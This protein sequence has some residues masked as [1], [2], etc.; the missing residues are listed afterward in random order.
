MS[1]KSAFACFISLRRFAR[2]L[3]ILPFLSLFSPVFPSAAADSPL[4]AEA[5]D[6]HYMQACAAYGAG[7]FYIPGTDTCF[8][9]A[10]YVRS[11][12]KG[13]DNVYGRKAK[14]IRRDTYAWR[15]RASLRLSTAS[16]TDLGTLRS[17]VEF[18]SQWSAGAEYDAATNSEQHLRFAYLELG[19]LRLGMDD[20]IFTHWTNY[21]GNV[22]N[23]DVL[24]PMQN[25]R[26]NAVSYSFDTGGGFSAILGVEQG[27]SEGDSSGFR[28]Q[29]G[30]GKQVYKL[31]QQ[32]QD[33]TPN[34]VGGVKWT[35]NKSAL[36]AV[37]AY[38]AYYS[39]WAAQARLDIQAG[40]RLSLWAMAGYK[41]AD[42]YYALD[43]SPARWRRNKS[44]GVMVKQGI[45]R[46]ISSLYGDWGGHWLFLG[47]G[48]YTLTPQTDFNL[49][50]GYS[51]DKSFASS[52]NINHTLVPG[53]SL[54]PEISYNSWNSSY[55][56]AYSD[57]YEE[58]NALKG[59]NAV[60]GMLRLQ[61]SF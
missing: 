11:D 29:R 8:R 25:A 36:A 48:T 35:G 61:R 52:A 55:G 41:S 1:V 4:P 44:G 10:G 31:R 59:R 58:K 51:S 40:S 28:Y 43:D 2:S 33:Y 50:L 9:I 22:L 49:Q 3:W 20:S 47:G 6:P 39:E 30:G 16:D 38:D 14:T 13:G 32:I 45:Y 46:Q 24:T 57:A 23:D 27:S 21:H 19:G 17:F 53:L 15:S 37:A 54:I 7:F 18:R 42:D 5:E 60:Q 12:A 56:Y 34:I 26:T